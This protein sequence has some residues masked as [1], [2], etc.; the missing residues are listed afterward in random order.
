M[1]HEDGGLMQGKQRGSKMNWTQKT[2]YGTDYTGVIFVWKK[3]SF[4]RQW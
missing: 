2:S 3:Y 4:H 1:W